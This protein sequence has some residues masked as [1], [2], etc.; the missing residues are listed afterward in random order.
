MNI[1]YS[2]SKTGRIDGPRSPS[3]RGL[4]PDDP[5]KAGG[6]LTPVEIKSAQTVADDFFDMLD[7]WKKLAGT[8]EALAVLVYGGDRQFKRSGITVMPWFAL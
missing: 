8:P 1:K 6:R 7:Y 4:G 2:I 5:H 3:A